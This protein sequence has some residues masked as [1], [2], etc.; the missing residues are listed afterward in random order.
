MS[1]QQ[2]FF[3]LGSSASP[4]LAFSDLLCCLGCC[5]PFMPP[6]LSATPKLLLDWPFWGVPFF[7]KGSLSFV[8]V[9]RELEEKGYLSNV[10]ND[11]LKECVLANWI[12]PWQLFG[13]PKFLSTRGK[14]VSYLGK[15]LNKIRLCWIHLQKSF[16]YS[17]WGRNT[18]ICITTK[19]HMF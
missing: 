14:K 17:I 7:N 19:L 16:G 3:F 9:H 11:R 15:K 12:R 10:I 4:I 8:G 2:P 6:L 5:W 18:F 1:A 13:Q